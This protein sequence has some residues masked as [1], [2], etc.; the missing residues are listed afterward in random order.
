MIQLSTCFDSLKPDMILVLA[1]RY[2][3]LAF[4][5]CA[6]SMNIP[7]AHLHPGFPKTH[8]D[9][10]LRGVITESLDATGPL[11]NPR[12]VMPGIQDS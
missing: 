9:D 4:A 8:N 12:Y 6:M 2:E 3:A 10:F 7:I 11:S 5:S 1:D